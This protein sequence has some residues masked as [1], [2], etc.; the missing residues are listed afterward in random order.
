MAKAAEVNLGNYML[1]DLNN[2]TEKITKEDHV[3]GMCHA[4]I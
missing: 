4:H 1:F 3:K 2:S